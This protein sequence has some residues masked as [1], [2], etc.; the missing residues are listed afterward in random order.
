MK[1]ISITVPP[2][3]EDGL[4]E[5]FGK[6]SL[7]ER[8]GVG[9]MAEIFLAK[10]EGPEGFSKTVVIKRIRPNLSDDASFVNMFLNEAK[11]AARLNHSNIAQIFEL[12]RIGKSYF[13]AMEYI[14]GRDMRAIINK[15]ETMGIPFPMEYSL[16]I[17]AEICEGL[18]YAHQKNDEDGS[19]LNI[20]HRDITPENVMVSFDGEVKILDFGIAK[21]KIL[22]SDTRVGEIKGKAGY[23]SP[24]QV[25]GKVLDQRSDLFGVGVVLYEWLAG[26]KLF[27]GKADIEMLRSVLEGKIVPPSY[28]RQNVPLEVDALVMKALRRN[29]DERHQTARELQYDIE[30]FLA[31]HEFNPSKIHLANFLRQIFADETGRGAE[32]SLSI[33]VDWEEEIGENEP[34]APSSSREDEDNTVV[35][36][37]QDNVKDGNKIEP[38]HAQPGLSAGAEALLAALEGDNS[39]PTTEGKAVEILLPEDPENAFVTVS[40]SLE[41]REYE[42]I[43]AVADRNHLSIEELI[44]EV[45]RQYTKYL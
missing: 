30:Q 13:I 39:E 3:P 9:G 34:E 22:V 38:H 26:R 41:R 7:I 44:Q 8:I 17:T 29:R 2:V 35:V 42:R 24:E 45:L 33:V 32:D 19:P 43:Q 6:Y 20:V 21:A 31:N 5:T 12:G 25:K 1:F 11:L 16:K 37:S 23:L 27:G 15:S 10:T 40:V 28:F 14:H 18:Y 4:A 36:A